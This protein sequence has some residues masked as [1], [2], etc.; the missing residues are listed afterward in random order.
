MQLVVGDG[1]IT[2]EEFVSVA[3]AKVGVR[4][5]EASLGRVAASHEALAR[6]L[7][8]GASVYGVSTGVGG[9]ASY[10]VQ[11]EEQAELQLNLIRSHMVGVGEPLPEDVVRGALFARLLSLSRGYSGVRVEVVKALEALLNQDVLAVVPCY[12][13]LGA[14]GDLAPGAHLAALLLGEGEALYKG[15]RMPAAEALREAGLAPLKLG[16]KEALSLINGTHFTT[17]CAALAVSD[18]LPLIRTADVL[19]ALSLEALGGSP[20]PFDAAHHEA[21]PLEGQDKVMANVRRLVAGSRRLGKRGLQDPYSLRCAPQV[22]AAVRQAHRFARTAVEAELNACS[23]NPLIVGDR[24]LHGGDFHAQHLA[25]AMDLLS[26]ALNELAVISRARIRLLLTPGLS[27]L[28]PYLA[29]KPGVETGYMMAEYTAASLL[30][31]LRFL[32][33]PGCVDFVSVS[34]HQEDHASMAMS[35]ALKALRAVRLTSLMLGVE[36]CCA[37]KALDFVGEAL[38]TGTRL[39]Y[40]HIRKLLP[41]EEGDHPL[42]GEIEQ[43]A[44]LIQRG[45]PLAALERAQLEIE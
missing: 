36:L 41:A 17:S 8:R 27:D 15:R 3:R 13:S 45:E 10:V 22:H 16:Y 1:P 34:G 5:S 24:A 28:P 23:D 18:A 32:A 39:V 20:E 43:A 38:G 33:A 31:E 40:E 42:H 44:S 29:A 26:I 30:S 21:R 14:S 6:L 25:Q 7:R 4:V 37:L 2:L 35:C 12:G 11:Q 19:V 9:Q